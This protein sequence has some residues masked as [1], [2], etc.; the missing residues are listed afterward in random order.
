MCK[1]ALASMHSQ[2]CTR[3]LALASMHVQ[4][5]SAGVIEIIVYYNLY[6]GHALSIPHLV[7][8]SAYVIFRLMLCAKI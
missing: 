1:H 7:S 8:Q 5:E 2:A 4:A 6:G 3:K